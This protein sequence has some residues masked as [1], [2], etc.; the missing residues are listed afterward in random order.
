MTVNGLPAHVLLVHAIV[1]LVPLSALLIVLVAFW[2]AA[3]HRLALLTAAIAVA[4]LILVPITT[5]A[6]EW[7]EHRL[8]RTA[9]LRVH[10]HLGDD[11]LPWAIG[12]AVVALALYGRNLVTARRLAPDTSRAGEQDNPGST[13]NS[14]HSQIGGRSVTVALCV[15]AVVIAAGSVITVYQFG[16]SG[17]RAAWTG[18]FSPTG[19]PRPPH[20]TPSS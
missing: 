4:T 11:M 20:H 13:V 16:D 1:V 2:P 10:T 3:R 17:A 9:L 15:V 12:L 18:K 8:P 19:L 6:G 7:L 14:R 5:Q